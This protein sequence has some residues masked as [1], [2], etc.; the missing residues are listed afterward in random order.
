MGKVNDAQ[1]NMNLFEENDTENVNEESACESDNLGIIKFKGIE[2]SEI[3]GWYEL[4]SGYTS[5]KAVTY[6]SSLS[7]IKKVVKNFEYAEIIFGNESILGDLKQLI[8]N[9]YA[10]VKSIDK[11][12]VEQIENGNLELYVTSLNGYTSHQKMYLL[13]NDMENKYRVITGS[14]NLSLQAFSGKQ[15]EAIFVAD[16]FE[17]YKM[18]L[19]IYEQTKI[20]S[21]KQLNAKTVKNL[22][23]TDINE[24]PVFKEV[25]EKKVIA[26]DTNTIDSQEESYYIMQKNEMQKL[27]EENNIDVDNIITKKS[28]GNKLITFQNVIKFISKIKISL[29]ENKKKY[30]AFPQ[31]YYHIEKNQMVFND[32]IMDLD[33]IDKQDI[34]NDIRIMKEFFDGYYNKELHFSGHLDINVKKYYA[35]LNYCFCAPFISIC[36]AATVNTGIEVIAYPLFLMLKGTTNAGKTQLMKFIL[37]LMFS[38]YKLNINNKGGIILPAGE[39]AATKLQEQIIWGRGIPVMVDEVTSARWRDYSG[40]FIKTDTNIYPN[41]S[42]VIM[43]TNDIKEVEESLNKRT[44]LFD[45]N[46]TINRQSNLRR[47][48]AISNLK[49]LTGALYKIYLKRFT[50]K[51]PSFLEK[52]HDEKERKAPDLF[53]FSSEILYDI[54]HEFSENINEMPY[55]QIFDNEYYLINANYSEKK[56]DFEEF[57]N[58]MGHLWKIDRELDRITITF[59]DG[60]FD[61]RNFQRKYS[62]ELKPDWPGGELVFFKLSDA[63]QYLGHSLGRSSLLD[64]LK[65]W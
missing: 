1:L 11:Y 48:T 10:L 58:K 17:T 41:I 64:K 37:Q 42:P 50:E 21:T 12:L 46:M 7:M 61:A 18:F 29:D 20:K 52:F 60:R 15:L 40:R 56:M 3:T 32:E 63:E 53:K 47:K 57:Y 59:K 6:S 24:L 27:I 34:Q 55:V 44:V 22:K 54:L 36:R 14:A 9:Q 39:Y 31:F 62:T 26:L 5:L 28:K 38:E 8:I 65:F 35:C 43:A 23:I 33:N 16:D 25:E 2:K 4:F 51:F 13:A 49:H 19:D 30:A 45:I